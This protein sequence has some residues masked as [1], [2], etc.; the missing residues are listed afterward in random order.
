MHMHKPCKHRRTL[1]ASTDI[2]SLAWHV[3]V[4]LHRCRHGR[5]HACTHP[6]MPCIHAYMPQT[7]PYSGLPDRTFWLLMNTNDCKTQA[8][9]AQT[10]D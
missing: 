5:M 7:I 1:Q 9:W 4:L 10:R 6:C 3:E 2:R 8:H